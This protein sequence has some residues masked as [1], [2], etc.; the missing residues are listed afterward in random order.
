M[1]TAKPTIFEN[2]YDLIKID[3]IIFRIRKE[4]RTWELAH[5]KIYPNIGLEKERTAGKKRNIV[6][7]KMATIRII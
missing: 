2:S 6:F 3:T 1:N 5:N 7:T 4:T